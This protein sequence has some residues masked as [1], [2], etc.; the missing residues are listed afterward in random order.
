[1]TNR[2]VGNLVLILYTKLFLVASAWEHVSDVVALLVDIALLGQTETVGSV[3]FV[4]DRVSGPLVEP[5][6]VFQQL[7]IVLARVSLPRSVEVRVRDSLVA[8]V[9]R[10]NWL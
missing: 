9:S 8:G 1:M 2:K 3:P 5:V 10:L 4:S 6:V 7:C